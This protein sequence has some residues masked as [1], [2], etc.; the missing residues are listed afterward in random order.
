MHSDIEI[1]ELWSLR[2]NPSDLY[3]IERTRDDNPVGGGGDTY[4]QV[5]KNQVNNLLS[6]LH[7]KYPPNGVSITLSVGNQAK[8]GSVT[9]NIEFKSKSASRMRISNQNRHRQPRLSAWSPGNGFPVLKP[10]QNTDDARDLLKN[11]GGLH[12]FI[13]RGVEGTIWAGYTTGTP[14]A[15]E[16]ELPFTNILWGNS[17]GGYWIYKDDEL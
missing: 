4:I 15:N 3:N 14:S 5:P 7:D 8:P 6:F 2:L 16:K 12:I 11:I 13:A 1:H 17:P 9:E 10:S